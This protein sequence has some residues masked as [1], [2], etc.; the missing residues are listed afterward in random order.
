MTEIAER[1][2]S[3]LDGRVRLAQPAEGYRVAID[4]VLLAAAV[5][6]R[7]GDRVLDVGCGSGAVALCLAARVP[8][9][10]LA[11]LERDPA[12]AALARRNA[13]LNGQDVE[14]VEGDLMVVAGSLSTEFD[15]VVAN[16][17]YLAA[18][19][20][21]A[22]PDPG[23]AAAHVEGLAGIGDWIRFMA[24]CA[25]QKGRLTLIHRADRLDEVLGALSTEGCGETVVFPLW[26]KAGQAAKRVIVSARVGVRGPMRLCA[27][28][29]LHA[30]D[31]AYTRQAEAVLRDAAALDFELDG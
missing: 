30:P 15:H 23:K 10:R 6:A 20:A 29:V 24:E 21:D 12:A 5:P 3:L 7:A 18:G 16:P 27:G 1:V 11:G 13:E 9:L 2:D 14:V 19:A 31:G 22:P 25:R 28:L 8:G 17:P 4:P 26:P